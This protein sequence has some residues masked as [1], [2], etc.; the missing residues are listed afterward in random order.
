[1]EVV[2]CPRAQVVSVPEPPP[3]CLPSPKCRGQSSLDEEVF[4][5]RTRGR[6][7]PGGGLGQVPSALGLGRPAQHWDSHNSCHMTRSVPGG[8]VCGA[9][10]FS[11]KLCLGGEEPGSPGSEVGQFASPPKTAVES[12]GLLGKSPGHWGQCG[13]SL[14]PW[15]RCHP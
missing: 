4:Q 11:G 5:H 12:Q 2:G 9:R 14:V 10:L 6:G 13:D 8:T 1:M 7:R 15:R 3:S